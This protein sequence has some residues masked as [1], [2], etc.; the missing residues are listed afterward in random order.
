[1]ALVVHDH[2][3]EGPLHHSRRRDCH[4]NWHDLD[5]RHP[6]SHYSTQVLYAGHVARRDRLGSRVD[7][8]VAGYRQHT[9]TAVSDYVQEGLMIRME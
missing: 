8:L 4:R 3:C 9:L 1:M 7:P 6:N 2:S 5:L